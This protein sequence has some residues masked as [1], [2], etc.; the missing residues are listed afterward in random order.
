M[1]ISEIPCIDFFARRQAPLAME[2]RFWT[3]CINACR[4]AGYS[5]DEIRCKVE[6]ISFI[7]SVQLSIM[8]ENGSFSQALKEFPSMGRLPCCREYAKEIGIDMESAHSDLCLVCPLSGKTT[9]ASQEYAMLSKIFFMPEDE[10]IG[11]LAGG[12]IFHSHMDMDSGDIFSG[13]I[14]APFVLP[15]ASMIYKIL[16]SDPEKYYCGI[17]TALQTGTPH[18]LLRSAEIGALVEE[19]YKAVITAAGEMEHD[20]FGEGVD[21]E[22]VKETLLQYVC[23]NVLMSAPASDMAFSIYVSNIE[24]EDEENKEFPEDDETPEP[25]PALSREE[26]SLSAREAATGNSQE[27]V[28]APVENR[29]ELEKTALKTHGT[30]FNSQDMPAPIPYQSR[31]Y[32]IP[33]A[34]NEPTSLSASKNVILHHEIQGSV[35]EKMIDISAQSFV[36]EEKRRQEIAFLTDKV[37]KDFSAAVEIAYVTEREMYILLIWNAGSRK[38]DYVPLI[39]KASGAL[40]EIPYPIIQFLKSEKRRIV[41]FQPYLLCGIC[42]LYDRTIELKT[43]Y[44]IYSHFQV[45][46]KRASCMIEDIFG[47]YFYTFDEKERYQKD[48]FYR[49]Y[50]EDAF[51][52]AM[53]PLYQCVAEKQMRQARSLDMTGLCISQVHKDLMYGYSYLGCGIYPSR[54]Q[55]AFSLYPNGHMEFL[56]PVEPAIS[57]IPGYIIEF[58]FLSEDS[59]K[60]MEREIYENRQARKLLLKDLSKL[61]AAFYHNDLKILY[62]DDFRIV[63]FVT[64]QYRA[65]HTT[66]I[67]QILM[68]ETYRHKVSNK[69]KA[70]FWATSLAEIRYIDRH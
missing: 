45:L 35:L 27:P 29:R 5:L 13:T 22:Q 26:I 18:A 20:P 1:N 16:C 36:S 57:Y 49:E 12:L 10:G 60:A 39:D 23:N 48:I 53:M 69:M 64:P 67:G 41:C 30:W 40:K 4:Q 54:K 3:H 28:A 9:S 59:P 32:Q 11:Y 44:S 52:L 46:T 65:V 47:T 56:Y 68:H 19:V 38:F 50:G 15:L 42:S 24:S 34:E 70:V 61:Q 6:D 33:F 62:M 25:A 43:I 2:P 14:A 66:D 37:R 63:F 21:K 55:A 17:R 8:D 31:R 58:C 51:F 7:Y